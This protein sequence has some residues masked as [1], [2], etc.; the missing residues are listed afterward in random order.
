MSRGFRAVQDRKAQNL[1]F[2]GGYTILFW[3]WRNTF[4]NPSCAVGEK[5]KEAHMRSHF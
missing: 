3:K 5:R 1:F 4:G 2:I